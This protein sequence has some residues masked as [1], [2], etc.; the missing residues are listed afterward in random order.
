MP[1]NIVCSNQVRHNHEEIED[2]FIQFL[3]TEPNGKLVEQN[4][5]IFNDVIINSGIYIFSLKDCSRVTARFSYVYQRL[6][7]QWKIITHHSSRMPEP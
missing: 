6:D 7:E 4:I 1:Q 5:Q 3:E 2:Y